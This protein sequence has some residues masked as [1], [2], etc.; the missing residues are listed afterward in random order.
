MMYCKQ[1]FKMQSA[2]LWKFHRADKIRFGIIAVKCKQDIFK[3]DCSL[4]CC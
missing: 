1:K 3:V 4:M 2:L